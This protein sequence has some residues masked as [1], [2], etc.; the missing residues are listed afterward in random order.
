MTI[1]IVTG[2][3]PMFGS[4]KPSSGMPLAMLSELTVPIFVAVF[5]LKMSIAKSVLAWPH[6]SAH[7]RTSVRVALAGTGGPGWGGC[8]AGPGLYLS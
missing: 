7:W 5:S 8:L 1:E 2:D 3:D 4:V 6:G